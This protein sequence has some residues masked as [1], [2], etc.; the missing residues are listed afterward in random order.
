MKHKISPKINVSQ[1]NLQEAYSVLPTVVNLCLAALHSESKE[2][3]LK[4]I[5]LRVSPI[6]GRDGEEVLEE[7]NLA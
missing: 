7:H 4:E 2:D 5:V 6:Y 3:Y 1:Q